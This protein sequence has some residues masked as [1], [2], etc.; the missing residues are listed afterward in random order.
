M[1]VL[2]GLQTTRNELAQS[3]LEDKLNVIQRNTEQKQPIVVTAPPAEKAGEGFRQLE[4]KELLS[5]ETTLSLEAHEDE[6]S[7]L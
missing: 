2:I 3:R 6:F 7:I 5:G 4:D 1:A